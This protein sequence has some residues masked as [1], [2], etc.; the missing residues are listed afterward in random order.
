MLA[1]DWWREL[2][3][4]DC[5]VF[6]DRGVAKLMTHY[7]RGTAEERD[8]ALVFNMRGGSGLELWQYISRTPQPPSSQTTPGDLGIYAAKIRCPNITTAHTHLGQHGARCPAACR[9]PNTQ[10][11]H[12]RPV[13]LLQRPRRQRHPGYRNLGAAQLFP[14]PA[15]RGMRG[16]HRHLGYR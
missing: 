13:L 12:R 15:R 16:N 7:T 9:R 11:P 6:R 3:G 1:C 5:P 8:A 10:R 14:P 4:F 2:F